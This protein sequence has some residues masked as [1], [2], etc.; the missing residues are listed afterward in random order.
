[1]RPLSVRVCFLVSRNE[2]LHAMA[3]GF[4]DLGLMVDDRAASFDF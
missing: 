2:R 4:F 3:V 1:M